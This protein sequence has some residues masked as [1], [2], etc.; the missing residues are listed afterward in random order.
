MT[1][2]DYAFAAAFGPL[3]IVWWVVCAGWCMSVWR[4]FRK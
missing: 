4:E 3:L 1:I 2:A